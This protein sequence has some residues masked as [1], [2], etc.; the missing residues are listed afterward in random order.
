MMHYRDCTDPMILEKPCVET[1]LTQKRRVLWNM[2]QRGDAFVYAVE[3][4]FND[5]KMYCI[6]LCCIRLT[7]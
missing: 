6:L 1:V 2:S 4:L 3:H 5:A 7:L